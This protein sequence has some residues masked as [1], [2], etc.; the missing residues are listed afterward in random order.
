MVYE[1]V[2]HPER[3]DSITQVERLAKTSI[4]VEQLLTL[5]CGILEEENSLT[6]RAI[7]V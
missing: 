6:V 4:I 3:R 2:P 7:I 1:Y 5:L